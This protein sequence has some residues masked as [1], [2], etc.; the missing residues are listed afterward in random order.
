M[1]LAQI[2][3]RLQ[4]DGLLKSAR[5]RADRGI[6]SS[7]QHAEQDAPGWQEDAMHYLRWFCRLM[8]RRTCNQFHI[9]AF[10]QWAASK[11]LKQPEELRSYGALTQRAIREKLIHPTGLYARA[12]SSN[13][14][15]KMIYQPGRN[16]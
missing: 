1:T 9:E 14:S 16:D 11:G 8:A 5:Q 3:Q 10:R 13:L 4:A 6:K 2:T 15:P 12:V 7:A